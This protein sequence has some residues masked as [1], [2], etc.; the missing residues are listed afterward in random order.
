VL[1]DERV[2]RMEQLEDAGLAMY[3]SKR[4]ESTLHIEKQHSVSVVA[5]WG[6]SSPDPRSAFVRI[7]GRSPDAVDLA[8]ESVQSMLR[9]VVRKTFKFKFTPEGLIMRDCLV[10]KLEQLHQSCGPTTAVYYAHEKGQ[11][12]L[13]VHVLGSNAAEVDELAQELN[14]IRPRIVFECLPPVPKGR[15]ELLN[16]G[17][18]AQTFDVVLDVNT[19]AGQVALAGYRESVTACIAR[20]FGTKTGST[21]SLPAAR[22]SKTSQQHERIVYEPEEAVAVNKL[23]LA[24]VEAKYGVRAQLDRNLR[25]ISIYSSQPTSVLRASKHVRSGLLLNTSSFHQNQPFTLQEVHP[26]THQD[27]RLAGPSQ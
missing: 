22:P 19:K 9:Q 26:N 3:L 20:V 16:F 5:L 21:T 14:R 2:D 11:L 24:I 18:L 6:Y 8:W 15:L 23:Q 12:P 10:S 27:V 25:T 4:R 7:G 13:T 1:S 17:Q